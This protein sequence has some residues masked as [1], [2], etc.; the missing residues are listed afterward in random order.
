MPEIHR[1]ATRFGDLYLRT[2]APKEA[3]DPVLN[4]DEAAAVRADLANAEEEAVI[5]T[6]LAEASEAMLAD[7]YAGFRL[8]MSATPA[9]QYA[10][11][12]RLRSAPGRPEAFPGKAVPTYIA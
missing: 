9:A 4:L 3:G 8:E 5:L 11:V 1:I 2:S 10:A 6:E 7:A 12:S